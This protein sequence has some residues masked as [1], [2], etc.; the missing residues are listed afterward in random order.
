MVV[1]L[2][3]RSSAISASACWRKA[4]LRLSDM[5]L[6]VGYPVELDHAL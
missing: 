1:V 3:H 2:D 6:P 5:T 4:S